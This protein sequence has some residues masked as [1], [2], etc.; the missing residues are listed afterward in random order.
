[1]AFAEPAGVSFY[2][3]SLWIPRGKFDKVVIF[4]QVIVSDCWILLTGKNG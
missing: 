2:D 3:N 4:V 1:M